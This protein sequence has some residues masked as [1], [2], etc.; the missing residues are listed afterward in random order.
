M[1]ASEY[2]PAGRSSRCDPRGGV[3][4]DRRHAAALGTEKVGLDEA[5]GRVVARGRRLAASTSPASTG[6]RWTATR[7]APRTS[8]GRCGWSDEVAAGAAGARSPWAPGEAAR[9]FT[10]G[11]MPAGRRRRGAAGG[12]RRSWRR[13]H[14]GRP[15]RCRTRSNVRY[16]GEDVAAGSVVL[17]AGDAR[18]AALA[19]A[20]SPP[21]A[22]A[23]VRS[24]GARASPSSRRATSWSPPGT[25][26]RAGPDLRDQLAST[27]RALV[28]ARGRGGRRP[29]HRARRSRRDRGARP[30]RPRPRR[31]S[32]SSPAA[33]R[34]ATTTTSRA[35]STA[36]AS[37]SSS[38]ACGSSRASRCSAAATADGT[39][40]FGLPGN[41]LSGVV[42]RSSSSS[43]RCC[44]GCRRGR[45]RRGRAPRPHHAGD[46]ARGRPH[47]L[48]D[49]DARARRRR[50]LRRDADRPAGLGD[51]ARARPG[52][53]VHRRAAHR[54]VG[55]GGRPRRRAA[56]LL[57]S[58]SEA[59]SA[60]IVDCRSGASG[61][62][63]GRG[64]DGRAWSGARRRRRS[65]GG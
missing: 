40:A 23:S 38:G 61:R 35:R 30:P 33:S 58:R 17:P 43:S 55:P 2:P 50:H 31:T 25:A 56:A 39:W 29:R 22:S 27:L 46:R 64:D 6:R 49:R 7:C 13:R 57:R 5:V 11:A 47:H 12:G 37:R 60:R 16:R 45:R 51:D 54:A 53:R 20:P 14:R 10:G 21:R 63:R 62:V 24:S 18:R 41:P 9:I 26:A 42:R 8:P 15:M 28:R 65:A 48:P 3:G 34:S 1:R 59:S 44:A 36:P 4:A 52:G 32:C 19:D